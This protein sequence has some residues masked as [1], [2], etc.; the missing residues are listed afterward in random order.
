MDHVLD[1]PVPLTSALEDYLETIYE[2]V[3]DNKLARVRDIALARGV[4]SASVSPAMRRLSDLGLIRYVQR[5][6]I[7]LTETGERAAR[8]I[9]AR[10]QLLTRF[11][12]EILQIPMDSAS[13]DA[14]AMEHSLSD[15]G[16]DHLVQFFEFMH[17]CPDGQH[18]LERFRLCPH[19]QEGMPECS[20]CSH[21]N[22]QHCEEQTM[23]IAQLKPGDRAR[24]TQV[25]GTG[26]IRQRL[27]D[28][29]I[30]PDVTVEVERVAPAGDPIWIKL[31]GFQLSLRLK[32]ASSV[33]VTL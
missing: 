32:E 15:E 19:L 20:S 3:R 12:H 21:T 1:C 23:S 24:V 14:C 22:E 6:Y 17:I 10:H 25:N 33:L 18:F 9:Y 4:R 16:M 2:L 5:E 8:R 28:M 26:A 11:F 30:L 7:D 13:T 27:L 31:Q 29:G